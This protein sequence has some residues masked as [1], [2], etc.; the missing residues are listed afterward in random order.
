MTLFGDKAL[1]IVKLNEI[2]GVSPNPTWLVS[3]RKD[4]GKERLCEDTKG[5]WPATS[6]GERSSGEIHPDDTLTLDF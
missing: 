1:R 2:I 5:R 3:L 6:Q 4:K